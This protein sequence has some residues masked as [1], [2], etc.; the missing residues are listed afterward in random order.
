MERPIAAFLVSLVILFASSRASAHHHIGCANDT[1]R[2][3]TVTA[4]ITEIDW[5]NPHVHLHLYKPSAV[6]GEP[7][8]DLIVETQ[9]AYILPRNGLT[10]DSFHV[11]DTIGVVFWPAKDGSRRGFTKAITLTNGSTVEF[12][13]AQLGCPW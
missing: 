6:P 10:K 12:H 9:A 5:A 11:G 1:T 2:T 8:T 4:Q 3:E 13:I 7:T